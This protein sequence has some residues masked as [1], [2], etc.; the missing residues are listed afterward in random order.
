M[1]VNQPVFIRS[2][3]KPGATVFAMLFTL[4]SVGRAMVST[5]LSMQAYALYQ[6]RFGVDDGRPWVSA[7][8]L[9]TSLTSLLFNLVSP[10][11]IRR[12]Q[13]RWFYV[14]GIIIAGLAVLLLATDTIP[15]QVGGMI[16]RA[17][18]AAACRIALLLYIMDYIPR[19]QLV[20]SEPLRLFMSCIAWGVG[21]WLG[22]RLYVDHGMIAPALVSTLSYAVLLSYFLYLRLHDNPALVP[23][24]AAVRQ[25]SNPLRNVVHFVRQRRLRLGWSIAFGRSAWWSMFFVYPALY[26]ADHHL[27]PQWAGGLVGIGNFMLVTAPLISWVAQRV[28]IR[29]PLVFGLFVGGALTLSIPLFY[30]HPNIVGLLL[31]MGAACIVV[32]DSLGNI[33]FM[34]FVRS[35]ER[36]QMSPVFQT[37]IDL[38]DLLPSTVYTLLLSHF[39]F[40]AVFLASGLLTI[41]T[42]FI[43]LRLPKRL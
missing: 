29:A 34:R 22:V 40:R 27:D 11:F 3:A 12:L 32:L 8:F 42:G 25:F 13:R 6:H 7:T 23:Q 37:Y 20:K 1:D 43:A 4:D 18:A 21:P 9:I 38:S 14:C 15:G 36:N 41:A 24:G 26:A 35:R 16:F 28:G 5:V 2:L 19:H 39:D 10:I 31:L 33:P 30:D 17:L